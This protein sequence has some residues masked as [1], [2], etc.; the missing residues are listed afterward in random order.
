[1]A[2]VLPAVHDVSSGSPAQVSISSTDSGSSSTRCLRRVV[3]SGDEAHVSSY[4]VPRVSILQEPSV[5][6]RTAVE[7]K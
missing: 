5:A 2:S 3:L 6:A 1:M 4:S 7:W